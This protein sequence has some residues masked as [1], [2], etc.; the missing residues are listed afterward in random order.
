M[1]PRGYLSYTSMTLFESSPQAW[2]EY[3]LNGKVKRTT[4]AMALGKEI[5]TSL[6]TG[7]ETGDL[8]KDLVVARMPK[9]EVMDKIVMTEVVIDK[10][11]V[12]ILIR[13]DSR[14]EDFSGIK[15]YKTGKD[16]WTQKMVDN[17]DQITFYTTGAYLITKKIPQD[18]ELVWAPTEY[19]EDG[20]PTLTGEIKRFPTKRTLKDVLKMQVRM[21]KVWKEM[22]K[23]IEEELL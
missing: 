13:P 5:A 10:Y 9:F 20:R 4:R 12:K 22:E 2:V 6:E 14:R 16:E 23:V 11:K 17:D 15:E 3:Y 1:H 18:L 21:V 8:M 7:E 19:D